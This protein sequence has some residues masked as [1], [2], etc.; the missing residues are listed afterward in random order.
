MISAV[1]ET[2]NDTV[3]QGLREWLEDMIKNKGVSITNIACEAN[4]NRSQISNFVNHGEHT[5]TLIKK[6]LE[7]DSRINKPNSQINLQVPPEQVKS[8][9]ENV[10]LN[11]LIQTEDFTQALGICK[12]CYE[13]GEMGVIIGHAG[14]GKTTAM[15]EFCKDRP[16][17]IYFR[18]TVTMSVKEMLAAIGEALGLGAIYGTRERLMKIIVLALK[19]CPETLII[20]EA[21]QLVDKHSITRLETLRAI[22]DQTH[23]GMVLCG[24]PKLAKYL[25]KG[26]TADDG[27]LAQVYSRIRR[28][29]RMKGVS[30]E[31]MLKILEQF[32]VTEGAKKY[33]LTRGASANMGGLRRF[34]RLMQNALQL[35]EGKEPIT[36][37]I[38]KE[39]D[40]LLVT[41]ETLG[42]SI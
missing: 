7:L 20:D 32:N 34:T 23:T 26:P 4:V 16:D 11:G 13:D 12:L 35:V 17:A 14:S 29:Y 30:R 2:S 15:L 31:E 22:W 5:T 10:F 8:K 33:L 3:I 41:P 9:K 37:D 24:M 28:A 39:A 21:D 6:L 19:T 42:V 1:K 18:G 27:N 36:L 40:S 25:V 38:V